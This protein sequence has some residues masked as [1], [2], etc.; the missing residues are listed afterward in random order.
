[1]NDISNMKYLTIEKE[2]ANTKSGICSQVVWLFYRNCKGMA[3]NPG[4][5][6]ARIAQS[7]LVSLLS[8]SLFYGIG[9]D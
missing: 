8:V 7:V 5:L 4:A 9:R 1:M 6:L 2:R 3:L